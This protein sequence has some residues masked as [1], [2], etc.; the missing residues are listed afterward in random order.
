MSKAHDKPERPQTKGSELFLRADEK[1]DKG[2]YRAAFRLF[3][4]SAKAGDVGA[5]V[6]LG[7]FYDKGIGIRPSRFKALYWYRRAFRRGDASAANNIGTIWRDEQNPK[8]ALLWFEKAVLLGDEGS[9]LEIAK[10]YLREGNVPKAIGFLNKVC[11]SQSISEADMEEA[12]LLLKK[13]KKTPSK[14]GPE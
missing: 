4:A 3:L 11:G 1:W 8:L 12:K 2:E 9:N 7:Y 5:Q 10:H 6:N 14:K 13:A